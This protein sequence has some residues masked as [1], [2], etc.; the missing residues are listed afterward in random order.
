MAED[1]LTR[2]DLARRPCAPAPR[3]RPSRGPSPRS[4]RRHAH[5]L[6]DASRFRPST[7]FTGSRIPPPGLKSAALVA[8]RSGSRRGSRPRSSSRKWVMP[9]PRAHSRA[10]R[11]SSTWA[12]QRHVELPVRSRSQSIP[13]S[14]GSAA[15]RR[16]SRRRG[17]PGAARLGAAE[18]G[19]GQLVAVVDRSR[20]HPGVAAAGAIGGGALLDHRDVR[21]RVEGLQVERGPEAGEARADDDEA[22]LVAA[23]ERRLGRARGSWRQPVASSSMGRVR[24]P[25]A[26]IMAAP[27]AALN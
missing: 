19:D 14:S 25:R 20:Q 18:V 26:G 1:G 16:C 6:P 27:R 22:G 12:R 8:V 2:A 7:S 9:S 10:A 11:R 23:L 17:P 21:P 5:A 13:R 15:S 24:V 3:R 4:V